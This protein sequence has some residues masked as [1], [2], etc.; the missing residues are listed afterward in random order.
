MAKVEMI[1]PQPFPKGNSHHDSSR[2]RGTP[3]YLR[4]AG[5]KVC[6]DIN[7]WGPKVVI[8]IC[9]GHRGPCQNGS[10]WRPGNKWSTSQAWLT[11]GLLGHWIHPV[12][13][14]LTADCIIG[15]D[16]LGSWKNPHT[17]APWTT[18]NRSYCHGEGPRPR[19]SMPNDAV[20]YVG[21]AKSKATP[22]T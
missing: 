7:T 3:R 18:Q 21:M 22:K 6:G 14:S 2:E 1:I 20:F 19:Q 12:A 17:G 9:W 15:R 13:I 5:Q 4:T 11:V 10:I 8:L 16:T